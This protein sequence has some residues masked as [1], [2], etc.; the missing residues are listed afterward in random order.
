MESQDKAGDGNLLDIDTF[1]SVDL[2]VGLIREVE[3]HPGADRLYIMKVD[4]GDRVRQIVAGLKPYMPPEEL[5]GSRVVVVRNLQP[6]R[7]RGE[8]SEGMI[9]ASDNGEGGVRLVRASDSAS[10]GDRVR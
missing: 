2:R 10:P 8:V 5:L 1:M 9:L 6:A 4:T 7:L 3:D